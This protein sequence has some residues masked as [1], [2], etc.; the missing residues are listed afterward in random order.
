MSIRRSLAP[1]VLS[2]L[3]T[4]CA[5]T[6]SGPPP[7]SA[8][9]VG[10]AKLQPAENLGSLSDEELV[11]KLMAQTGAANLG[12]QMMDAM[13]VQFQSMGNMPPGFADKL[14]DQIKPEELIAKIRP[15]YLRH[16]DRATLV[17]SIRF[18]ETPAGKQLIAKMP[19]VMSEAM[20]MGQ[21]W[22]QEVAAKLMAA[23]KP[24]G[25]EKP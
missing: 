16:Y 25:T 11:D 13:L 18:Y 4:A 22:G 23:R 21:Q 1:F 7:R 5:A 14:R 10:A 20:A 8:D 6:P 15:I 3:G 19:Q 12:Q 17:A 2:L 9:C 24:E